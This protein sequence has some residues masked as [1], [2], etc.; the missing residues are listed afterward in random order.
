[1]Y[2][3]PSLEQLKQLEQ[4]NKELT[5]IRKAEIVIEKREAK[6]KKDRKNGKNEFRMPNGLDDWEDWRGKIR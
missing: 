5:R 6:K 2:W 1:M 3:N 4:R